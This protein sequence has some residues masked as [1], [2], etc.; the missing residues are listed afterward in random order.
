[1][2]VY[3]GNATLTKAQYEKQ[4]KSFAR[5]LYVAETRSAYIFVGLHHVSSN[6]E[7]A[8]YYWMVF[9]H[10]SDSEKESNHSTTDWSN[11]RL[12][13]AALESAS[14]LNPKFLEIVRLSSPEGMV[15]VPSFMDTW[16]PPED[17]FSTDRVTLLGDAAHKM[18]PCEFSFQ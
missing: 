6:H 13:Q 15:Q 3:I 11:E 5:S 9:R 4:F 16:A 17:G 10:H 14:S 2:D 7:T 1:M 18:T 8:Y 12:Y